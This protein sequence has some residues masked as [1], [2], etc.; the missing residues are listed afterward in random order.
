MSTFRENRPYIGHNTVTLARQA[1]AAIKYFIKCNIHGAHSGEKQQ[2]RTVGNN[3][4]LV[5]IRVV[6]IP[7]FTKGK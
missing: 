7:I 6:R 2:Q 5:D 3:E 4:Q 1:L